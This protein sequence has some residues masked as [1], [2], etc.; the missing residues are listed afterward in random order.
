VELLSPTIAIETSGRVGSIAVARGDELLAEETFPHGLQH[1]AQLIPIVDRLIRQHGWKPDE[2]RHL[3]LSIGPGSFT[4][5]RIAVTVAKAL[6][7]ATGVKIVAVPSVRV[8][9]E[10]APPEAQHAVVV[11]DAKRG[12]IFTARF[13]R[14]TSQS[15]DPPGWSEIEPAHLD[16]LVAMI[17]R[18]PRP[19][20]LIGEGID[21]HRDSIPRDEHLVITPAESWRARAR[22]V[23][24]LGLQL[25]ALDAFADPWALSPIYIRLPE[26]EEKWQ[27][28]RQ[29]KQS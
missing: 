6:A 26:A 22:V 3:F 12:Q 27:A 21:Y 17:R 19:L 14:S 11:L 16:T 2:V 24:R 4:G 7:M 13:S 25:A 20:H 23:W 9:V 8:L 28:A 5:L 18:A 1:A 10:N 15:A 29:E